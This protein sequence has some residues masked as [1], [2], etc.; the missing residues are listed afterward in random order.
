MD[1]CEKISFLLNTLLLNNWIALLFPPRSK[2]RD[3]SLDEKYSFE[4]PV[5]G[6]TLEGKNC[7]K[8]GQEA[9]FVDKKYKMSP[10]EIPFFGVKKL[11]SRCGKKKSKFI[12]FGAPSIEVNTKFDESGYQTAVK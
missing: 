8:T 10:E 7:W 5:F 4:I 9:E 1:I 2:D 12:S 11:V 6:I 3:T